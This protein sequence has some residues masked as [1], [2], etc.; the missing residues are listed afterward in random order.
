MVKANGVQKASECYVKRYFGGYK[1]GDVQE[2]RGG[3]RGFDMADNEAEG[4][5][6][7]GRDM[8]VG[9]SIDGP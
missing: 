3:S 5:M 4:S 7:E 1:G 6:E 8:E 9:G 2:A